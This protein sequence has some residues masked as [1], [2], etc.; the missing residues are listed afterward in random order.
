MNRFWNEYASSIKL[1]L[2]TTG[3]F[4]FDGLFA[5]KWIP[6]HLSRTCSSI[7]I[8]DQITTCRQFGQKS[9]KMIRFVF[10]FFFCLRLRGTVRSFLNRILFHIFLLGIDRQMQMSFTSRF[11]LSWNQIKFYS[12]FSIFN[13]LRVRRVVLVSL[14]SSSSSFF[15]G[16]SGSHVSS[17]Y[18]T[19]FEFLSMLSNCLAQ[20]L[21]PNVILRRTHPE[22]FPFFDLVSLFQKC[23]L[24]GHDA[25]FCTCARFTCHFDHLRSLIC[26]QCACI[27]LKQADWFASSYS[28]K[29]WLW[30]TITD[31]H[32]CIVFCFYFHRVHSFCCSLV[33]A[34]IIH[35]VCLIAFGLFLHEINL[36]RFSHRID[37]FESISQAIHVLIKSNQVNLITIHLCLVK[38][39]FQI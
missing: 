33:N 23:N 9:R 35:S 25:S 20:N 29:Y 24:N 3:V 30:A 21:L 16:A 22:F 32:R 28:T 18:S 17:H 15:C 11:D 7:L 26:W 38:L 27:Q 14:H 10:N 13:S 39:V 34:K 37:S 2:S 31:C 19:L 5:P 6:M 12:L 36:V 4:R 1:F 8:P